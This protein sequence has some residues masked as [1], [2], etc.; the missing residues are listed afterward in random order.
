[1]YHY[2]RDLKHSR[3]PAIKGLSRDR[4]SRQ[5]DYI[6]SHYTPITA[7]QLIA[8]SRWCDQGLPQN[9]ILLTFDDGYIDHFINVFPMLDARGIKGCFFPP[10]EA[11]VHHKVLDVNKIHFL[12]ASVSDTTMLLKKVFAEMDNLRSEFDLESRDFYLSK[13]SEAHRYDSPEVIL[14]KRL[15]QRE[16]PLAARAEIVQRLFAEYVTT[17]ETA[18]ACEL[19]M[20]P[21]QITCMRRHGMHIGSHGYSHAWLNHLSG[22]EQVVEIDRSLEF[23]GAV[24]V[25]TDD[26]TMCYPY[27]GFNDSLLQ[28][29][30][31]RQCKLGFGVQPRVANLE[32]DGNLT[33]PRLDTNDLPS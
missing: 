18:F 6:Q 15:L 25:Q 11:I 21:E 31:A 13:V 20:S 7:E 14:L 22:D 23:L 24:G 19:Y 29:L 32:A 17:D 33:I 8:A 26:W 10:A 2:V 3:F 1:M 16:L 5:L 4:F 12:L 28:V 9:S 30:R 27:G